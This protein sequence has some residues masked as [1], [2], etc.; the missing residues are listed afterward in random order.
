[1]RVIGHERLL[2]FTAA[3]RNAL[4]PLRDY[5]RRFPVRVVLFILA[6]FAGI[7][8]CYC[9]PSP[10]FNTPTCTVLYSREGTLLAAS[11]A[12]DGQYRFPALDSVPEKFAACAIAY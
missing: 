1:M 2:L 7:A 3:T 4:L 8:F 9:L 10:L 5:V 6:L 12:D 11:I